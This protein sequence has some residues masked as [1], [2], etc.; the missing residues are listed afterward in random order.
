M[1]KLYLRIF[2]TVRLLSS[3]IEQAHSREFWLWIQVAEASDDDDAG[4]DFV[5]RSPPLFP[6]CKYSRPSTCYSR[7]YTQMR[8]AKPVVSVASNPEQSTNC[9]VSLSSAATPEQSTNCLVSLSSAATP[10]QITNCLVSLSSAATP[11]QSTNCLVFL[12]STA[13]PWQSRNY[14]GYSR[15]Q[16][17]RG[18]VR[19][20][21]CYSSPLH[22]V[23]WPSYI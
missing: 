13:N 22:L 16:L 23:R 9:L 14:L 7:T 21:S 8:R 12:S 18:R 11:E 5:A 4:P 2:S 1:L 17:T 19:T 6:G 10:G 15:L 20:V 3:S